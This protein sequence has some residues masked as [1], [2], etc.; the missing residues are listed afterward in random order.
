MNLDCYFTAYTKM[1]VK[2]IINLN[3]RV[4]TFKLPKE[5]TRE[6]LCGIGLGKDFLLKTQKTQ[7]TK[8]KKN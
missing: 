3:I 1:I 6:N 8:D 4:K 7:T 2:C 5:N